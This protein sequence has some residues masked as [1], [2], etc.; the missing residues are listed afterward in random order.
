MSVFQKCNDFEG[1]G[2]WEMKL[3]KRLFRIFSNCF[4]NTA[5]C[6]MYYRICQP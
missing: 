6:T 3:L 2:K 5:D 4:I 1:V